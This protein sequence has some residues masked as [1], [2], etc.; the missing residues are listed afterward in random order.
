MINSSRKRLSKK[1]TTFLGAL[2]MRAYTLVFIEIII[3]GILSILSFLFFVKVAKDVLEQEIIALDTFLSYFVYSFRTPQ[4]TE[5]MISVSLL[6]GEFIAIASIII[7]G[8]LLLKGERREGF[9]FGFAIIGGS[10][11]NTLI[12]G[13]LK[14]P[15]PT[16]DPLTIE[17]FYSFPSGHSMNSFIF[18]AMVVYLIF[19]YTRRKSLTVM[20]AIVACLLILLIGFSRVYLGVHYP[21]DVLAGFV[22]GFWWVV[23]VLAVDKTLQFYHVFRKKKRKK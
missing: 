15:R 2:H 20:M 16:L 9:I 21:T 22:A 1:I 4:L 5:G 14:V 23:T 7:I 13:L 3:G 18:Y 10:L 6:G 11:L 17:T 19:H 12:K 8:I